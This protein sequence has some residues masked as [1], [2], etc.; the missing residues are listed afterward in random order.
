MKYIFDDIEYLVKKFGSNDPF[1]IADCLKINLLFHNIGT[2]KGYYTYNR[3]FRYIVIN[4]DL[5]KNLQSII[6]AHELGHDRL[7]QH[8]ARFSP[9]KDTT[10]FDMSTKP[11]REANIFAAEMLIPDTKLIPLIKKNL[12]YGSISCLLDMPMD[13]LNFKVQ[14]LIKKGYKIK[15][16]YLAQNN[17]LA[18]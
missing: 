13:F 17:F 7:H 3:R 4:R 1:E 5:E 16:P 9:L 2:L 12:S 6:C 18:E 8:F 15:L 10:L 14:A 11:E